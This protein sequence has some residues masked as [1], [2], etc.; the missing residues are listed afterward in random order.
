M[1]KDELLRKYFEGETTAEEERLLRDY[2]R[3][4]D[5]PASLADC[6]PMFAY[7]DGE[8]SRME[9]VEPRRQPWKRMRR[10]AAAACLIP[11]ALAGAWLAYRQAATDPCLCSSGYVVIDGQCY[12]DTDR[13]RTL[14]LEALQEVATPLE[15]L[16]PD[17]DFF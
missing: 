10:F 1:N 12:A 16:L 15:T 8:I 2:A 17:G 5:A 13:A 4:D 3:R 14:A 7:F 9:A 6:R 11:A